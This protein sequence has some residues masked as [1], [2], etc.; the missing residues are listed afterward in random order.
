MK[1]FGFFAGIL[2]LMLGDRSW[3]STLLG[4]SGVVGGV[5]S[6][7]EYPGTPGAG[8]SAIQTLTIN[9]SPDAG[10]FRLMFQGITSVAL[11]N[12]PVNTD[13]QAALVALPGIGAGGVVVTGAQGG[14]F[15]ITWQAPAATPAL[16][17]STSTLTNGGNPVAAPGIVNG[18]PGVAPTPAGVKKGGL[19]QDTTNGFL[20][21]NTGTVSVP[22]WTKVGTQ[23]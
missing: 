17:V 6:P 14:P 12:N 5:S 13:V 9:G 21:I 16:V 15:T 4:F 23:S 19:V 7:Q 20:Y 2:A 10:T 1:R 3:L 11:G 8:T 18:T 22:T